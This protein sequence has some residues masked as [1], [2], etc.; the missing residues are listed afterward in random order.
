MEENKSKIPRIKLEDKKSTS[1]F[2]L[3]ILLFGD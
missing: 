2:N 3:F 1:L